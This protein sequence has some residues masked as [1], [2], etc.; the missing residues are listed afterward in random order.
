M[1]LHVHTKCV[2]ILSDCYSDIMY[3]YVKV[4]SK[5]KSA[6]FVKKRS[7]IRLFLKIFI[8]M[9][10]FYTQNLFSPSLYVHS[11]LVRWR[12]VNKHEEGVHNVVRQA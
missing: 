4:F 12:D 6:L 8:Y 7:C 11:N 5:R 1:K 2:Y 3:I 9:D 10:Y